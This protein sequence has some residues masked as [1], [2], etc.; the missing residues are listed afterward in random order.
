M[1]A[2]LAEEEGGLLDRTGWVGLG[3]MGRQRMKLQSRVLSDLSLGSRQLAVVK[4]GFP[5][6]QPAPGLDW[7]A[8]SLPP[9]C[10]GRILQQVFEK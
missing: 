7:P 5:D 1:T 9:L 6:T 2:G 10:F 3:P 4:P 8:S